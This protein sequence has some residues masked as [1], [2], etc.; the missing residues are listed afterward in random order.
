MLA[1]HISHIF[2]PTDETFRK[3][4]DSGG[5]PE[6]PPMYWPMSTGI[7]GSVSPGEYNP[8]LGDLILLTVTV[9]KAV[10]LA[11]SLLGTLGCKITLETDNLT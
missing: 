8:D 4:A 3:P 2:A 10:D 6:A 5:S 1:L 11:V 9:I 7:A